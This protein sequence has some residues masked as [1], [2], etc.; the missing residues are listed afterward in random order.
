MNREI[1]FPHGYQITVLE[2]FPP[3]FDATWIN[4]FKI[5]IITMVLVKLSKT[6]DKKNVIAEINQ[7]NFVLLVVFMLSVIF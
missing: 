3:S 2:E 7:I 5:E 6:A 1:S 4:L